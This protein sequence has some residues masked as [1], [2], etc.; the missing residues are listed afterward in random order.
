MSMMHTHQQ[1]IQRPRYKRLLAVVLMVNLATASAQSDEDMS[2]LTAEELQLQEQLELQQQQEE[3]ELQQL[4]EQMEVENAE[5]YEEEF[6]DMPLEEELHDPEMHDLMSPFRDSG[7]DSTGTVRD[8]EPSIEF[9]I[10]EDGTINI[11]LRR[12]SI[13]ALIDLIS[14]ATGRNFIV[15]PRVKATVDLVAAQPMTAEEL[16]Q[17]FLSVLQ[18]HGYSAVPTGGVTKILPDIRARSSPIPS[19]QGNPGG[20][21]LITQVVQVEHASVARIVPILRPLV[22]KEGQLMAYPPT[23]MLVISDRA[24]NVARIVAIIRHID[25]TD[26]SETELIPLQ[27]ATASKVAA[28]LI[29][30]VS[31]H[32]TENTRIPPTKVVVDERTNSIV[33]SGAASD[34]ARMRA[35]IADLDKPLDDE[36][37]NTRVVYLKYAKSS[38]LLPVLQGVL[39]NS[40]PEAGAE[41]EE[42]GT[43]QMRST[44]VVNIQADERTNALVITA[45]SDISSSL[46]EII[47]QLD[48]RQ[49]QVLVEAI[50][51]EVSLDTSRS[52][53][54]QFAGVEPARSGSDTELGVASL[55]GTVPTLFELNNDSG[56]FDR[57]GLLFGFSDKRGL[58]FLLDAL[59]SDSASNIL[60]TPSVVT[61]DNKQAEIV[62][63]QN[64]PFI[65][66]QFTS[67]GSE[68]PSSPFQTIERQDVGITLRVTPQLSEAGSINLEIEQE[69]SSVALSSAIQA[70]DI[71]T[72]KRSIKTGVVV[73]DGQVIVL[74]GLID[75][76]YTDSQGKVPLLGDIPVL[77]N[78][79]RSNRKQ[80]IKRNLMIF[81]HPRILTDSVVAT[82]YTKKKY[83]FLRQ[84][85]QQVQSNNNRPDAALIYGTQLPEQLEDLT[86]TSQEYPTATANNQQSPSLRLDEQGLDL[87]EIVLDANISARSIER[88]MGG[89]R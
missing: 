18:V 77:G 38:E 85:Q 11:N 82:K 25:Q 28:L 71:V 2:E 50:I 76:T 49:A 51:A 57:K 14:K 69:I 83:S 79:F 13:R 19:M 63:A 7:F 20:D 5:F 62:V 4:Q 33:L 44:S 47:E 39:G 40:A 87:P 78:L 12:T 32:G 16:Y 59:L 66:G 61:K 89:R 60:S 67:S 55:L 26:S 48:I 30:L 74:G 81:I 68:D 6:Q 58:G 1:A 88:D 31:D 24:A 42:F 53:G 70:S 21:Q 64:V 9:N 65:T 8:A 22:P 56:G 17:V 72:N 84:Q 54:V 75:D 23:N 73:E 3:L 34:R 36:K 41:M 52:L 10:A 46:L 86:T 29:R 27:N 45:P 43:S 35:L 37:K 80:K 15:D